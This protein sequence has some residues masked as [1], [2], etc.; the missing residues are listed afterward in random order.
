MKK[1]GF[2]PKEMMV[3]LRLRGEFPFCTRCRCLVARY[4]MVVETVSYKCSKGKEI[5]MEENQ[6]GM[7]ELVLY[8]CEDFEPGSVK[9]EDSF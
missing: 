4:D 1:K 9:Y 3:A 7:V 8:P 6:N 5:L 2:I